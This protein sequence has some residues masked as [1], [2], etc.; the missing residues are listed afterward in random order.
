MEGSVLGRVSTAFLLTVLT[1][2]CI[3]VAAPT[4]RVSGEW[5]GT[6][7]IRPD[8]SID[9]PDA[10]IVTNPPYYTEYILTDNISSTGDGIIVER[11]NIV[12]NGNGYTIKGPG[13]RVGIDISQRTNITIKNTIIK[14]FEYG[15][16]LCNS[17]NNNIIEN[18]I[19]DNQASGISLELSLNTNITWNTITNNIYYGI[20]LTCSSNNSITRNDIANNYCGISILDSSDNVIHHNNF[21]DNTIQVYV[22]INNFGDSV[23][24]WDCGY[25][26]GGN[27]WSDYT[28]V[29]SDGDGIGD[30]PYMI[31]E[32][33]VDRYPL[34]GPWQVQISVRWINTY[35]ISGSAFG[36]EEVY[37]RPSAMELGFFA[38][39]ADNYGNVLVDLTGVFTGDEVD[40][41]VDNTFIKSVDITKPNNL[42]FNL[43]LRLAYGRHDLTLKYM[44]E[45]YPLLD[46]IAYKNSGFNITVDAY[47]FSNWRLE[48]CEF[49]DFVI[50]LYEKYGISSELLIPL[51][52]IATFFGGHCFGMAYTASSYFMNILDKP[53]NI[54]VYAFD[55]DDAWDLINIYHLAQ[56]YIRL[57]SGEKLV[58]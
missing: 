19:V 9:P 21:M 53:I 4:V 34:M 31:D 6:V 40:V 55:K 18:I 5:S 38:V 52:A 51:Y 13:G 24:V 35:L 57:E 58:R 7:Y 48:F 36:E 50:W 44:K 12:I 15:I 17:L 43:M 29:D 27:Y 25:P 1:L 42:I 30:T 23:N 26:S 28:G 56:L 8:G 10:P 49:I 33:N 39:P 46:I 45:L 16:Y 37:Q 22:Y 41:L 54:D 20:N 11:D 32:N 47:R 2:A 3:S 14:N